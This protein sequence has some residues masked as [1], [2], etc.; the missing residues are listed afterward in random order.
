M[1]K[2]KRRRCQSLACLFASRTCSSN[3]GVVE[4]K[5]HVRIIGY[6]EKEEWPGRTGKA[7]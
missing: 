6:W 1:I 2:I 4:A 3:K 5:A 7:S